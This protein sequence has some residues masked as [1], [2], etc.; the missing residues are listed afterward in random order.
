VTVFDDKGHV[1]LV[2]A[3]IMWAVLSELAGDTADKW[4]GGVL[5]WP[6]G[7]RGE[8]PANWRLELNDWDGH[9]MVAV[10]GDHLVYVFGKLIVV[11][12]AEFQ[13]DA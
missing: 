1:E 7:E 9:S 2:S 5:V 12:A 10:L 8:N 4:R 3:N 6:E 11:T 13:P